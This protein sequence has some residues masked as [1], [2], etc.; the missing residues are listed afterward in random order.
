ML[1][2]AS[3]IFVDILNTLGKLTSDSIYCLKLAMDFFPCEQVW[4]KEN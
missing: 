4:T 2:A 1:T 3:H